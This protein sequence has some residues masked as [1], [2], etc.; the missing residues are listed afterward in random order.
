MTDR[1]IP[2]FQSIEFEPTPWSRWAGSL[3]LNC[4]A[5]IALL[6]IPVAVEQKFQKP[7]QVTEVS[8]T[9]PPP[10]TEFQ[11]V[12][13]THVVPEVTKKILIPVK[14]VVR[15]FVVPPV[16]RIEIKGP[17]TPEPEPP[18]VQ[19]AKVE[20]PKI[21]LPA[22]PVNAA[23]PKIIKTGGFGDPNGAPVNAEGTRTS[24]LQRVGAFDMS[25]GSGQGAGGSSAGRGRV[26]ANAGFGTAETAGP[27]GGNGH[28]SVRGA[29]FGEYDSPVAAT[30]V[31][32][33]AEPAKETPVEIVFKPKPAYTAEA[34]EKR[35]EGEV[36]LEVLFSS[37]GQIQVLKLV[38]GLGYGLDQNAR[39]AASEIRF[40]P[41]TR[42][43]APVDMTGMVHIVFQLS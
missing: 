28:G 39:Q 42:N 14:P 12:P 11:P 33:S 24:T 25:A 34:R 17:Q 13:K 26:V 18:P 37:A 36:L 15:T 6:L 29:G 3:G 16:K 1:T 19:V 40:H 7:E 4:S 20:A 38:R 2:Q 27:G 31:A 32:R 43:G 41:G 30:K 23:P 8:L 35:I 9:V 10:L 5:L 22:V 21:E